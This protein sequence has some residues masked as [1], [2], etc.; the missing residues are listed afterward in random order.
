MASLGLALALVAGCKAGEVID[1]TPP[2]LVGVASLTIVAPADTVFVADTVRLGIESRDARGNLVT[3]RAVNWSSNAPAVASILPN[4]LVTALAPGH[5]TFTAE[6]GGQRASVTLTVVRLVFRVN[7]VPDA[8]CLRRGFSTVMQLVAYDSL[9]QP[10]PAGLR[11]IVWRTTSGAI[12]AISPQRGDSALVLGVAA[13][14]ALVSA[15]LM[16]VADTAA[17]VVDPTPLG[18]PLSCGT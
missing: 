11:P 3:G 6:S 1:P 14:S 10:L 12:V 9:D 2:G 7:V 17:F 18:Q 16:G 5:I 13:G 4:G 8:V 15:S